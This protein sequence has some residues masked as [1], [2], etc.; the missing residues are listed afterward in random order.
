MFA[1]CDDPIARKAEY[2]DW[3]DGLRPGD[4]VRVVQP[5]NDRHVEGGRVVA[6]RVKRRWEHTIVIAYRQGPK[7]PFRNWTECFSPE[8]GA[9]GPYGYI[10]P[11]DRDLGYDPEFGGVI[12]PLGTVHG[13]LRKHVRPRRNL[14]PA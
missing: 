8:S 4:P 6:G 5:W 3:L 7:A 14:G 9:S 12:A 1:F 11:V 2:R 10:V 13:S